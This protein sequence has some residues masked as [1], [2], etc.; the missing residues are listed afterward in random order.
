MSALVTKTAASKSSNAK[1]ISKPD[2][3]VKPATIAKP[4]V[5]AKLEL[6]VCTYYLPRYGRLC[7]MFDANLPDLRLTCVRYRDGAQA[8]THFCAE[9]LQ[10]IPL[11]AVDLGILIDAHKRTPDIID[12][13]EETASIGWEIPIGG[14]TKELVFD[15]FFSKIPSD[16]I[17]FGDNEII[18]IRSLARRVGMLEDE[19]ARVRNTLKQLKNSR[20]MEM[21]QNAVDG[22]VN[23][24]EKKNAADKT[25]EE[26]K[27]KR[28]SET[29]LRDVRLWKAGAGPCPKPPPNYES[30]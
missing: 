10:S 4:I 23:N 6:S 9:A 13:Y 28:I 2:A 14:R 26:D 19:L 20:P 25:A 21:K 18:T 1:P 30:D 8:K 3:E 5:A 27:G 12:D 29:D 24:L 11:L 17:R 22:Y 15:F 7:I 16:L